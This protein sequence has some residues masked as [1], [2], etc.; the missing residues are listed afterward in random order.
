MFLI[1]SSL[2]GLNGYGL[3][4]VD[5][6]GL[7]TVQELKPEDFKLTRGRNGVTASYKLDNDKEILECSLSFDL[8]GNVTRGKAFHGIKAH[9]LRL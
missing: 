6:T 9:A 3:I 5:P 2:K 8:N 4:E 7:P 1:L